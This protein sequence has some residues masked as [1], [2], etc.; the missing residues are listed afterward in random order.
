MPKSRIAFWQ[1][2]FKQNVERDRYVRSRLRRA[3]WGAV[4]I[5]E[6]ETYNV[7]KLAE[8]LHRLLAERKRVTR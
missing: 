8:K 7:D 1:R 4:V 2:K 6:C 3:G 5:W